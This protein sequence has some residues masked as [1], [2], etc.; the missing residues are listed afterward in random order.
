MNKLG[1][2][3]TIVLV[4]S[5]VFVLLDSAKRNMR[6]ET[7]VPVVNC[8]PTA[9]APLPAEAPAPQSA[10]TKADWS[11]LRDAL[12]D[13]AEDT[14]EEDSDITYVDGSGAG[15]AP[16]SDRAA[17]LEDAGGANDIVVSAVFKS[18]AAASRAMEAAGNSLKSGGKSVLF[19]SLMRE[20]SGGFFYV[21]RTEP[22]AAV[23]N[24]A[25][26]ADAGEQ[27]YVNS[28][29]GAAAMLENDCRRVLRDGGDR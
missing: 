19:T 12:R 14:A 3:L 28:V 9:Q 10:W 4:S 11:G 17:Y 7:T 20:S 24:A 25:P 15:S 27:L 23:T 18:R 26:A 5:S 22:S 29:K 13:E 2:I 21:I 16:V 1:E 8:A 6:P